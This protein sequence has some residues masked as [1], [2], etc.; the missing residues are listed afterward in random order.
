MFGAVFDEA[1]KNAAVRNINGDRDL[2]DAGT[3]L[4]V[5]FAFSADVFWRGPGWT[6]RGAFGYP[7]GS[8]FIIKS[9]SF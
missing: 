8:L 1:A 6:G 2:L 3:H 7:G 5:V 4:S 9:I